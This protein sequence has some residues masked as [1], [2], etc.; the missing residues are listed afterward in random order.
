MKKFRSRIIYFLA[1]FISSGIA[2]AQSG[3]TVINN[4]LPEFEVSSEYG[5]RTH[6][7]YGTERPHN[8]VDL[9]LP[10]SADQ[11]HDI[12]VPEGTM[13]GGT[14]SGYGNYVIVDHG[15][16]VQSFYGHLE[17]YDT[18][19]RTMQVGNTGVGTGSH[20]HY[21]IRIQQ[22]DGTWVQVDPEEA[23][24][25]DLSDPAVRE[26]LVEDANNKLGGTTPTA[27][28]VEGGTGSGGG[29]AG[30]GSAGG[31]SAGGGSAGGG[32]AGGGSA[33]GG[34]AGGGSGGFGG[35]SG[36]PGDVNFGGLGMPEDRTATEGGIPGGD[37][38]EACDEDYLNVLR[39]QAWL[40]GQY[41]ILMNQSLIL[42]PDSVF[43]YTCFHQFLG[44]TSD[45]IAPIFSESQEFEEINIDIGTVRGSRIINT[46][47]ARDE[48]S[49]ADSL[50]SAVIDPLTTYLEN[51]F[52]HTFLGGTSAM[53]GA[54]P[55][56]GGASYTCEAMALVWQIAK[57]TN[58]HPPWLPEM[59]RGNLYEIE[60]FVGY[61]P[62]LYPEECD[63]SQVFQEFIDISNNEDLDYHTVDEPV[64]EGFGS[65]VELREPPCTSPPIPVGLTYTREDPVIVHD[66]VV[67]TETIEF[68]EHVCP[69][70]GC[71]YDP[72][73]GACVQ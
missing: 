73:A 50:T 5:M 29:S 16:G 17:G 60:D 53:D 69:N 55:A 66:L 21:E 57:C 37:G 47:F 32:S 58:F 15:N 34:S 68:Q 25:Q 28:V 14:A 35:G 40:A 6:P 72:E 63:N 27:G 51:N 36:A 43:E 18:E 59:G 70:Q 3:S 24:G 42:K 12:P 2:L 20:L 49:M 11:G 67:D 45:V 62:R 23:W 8:G 61:D 1:L 54:T 30:G 48:G 33:G 19:N 64:P 10:G 9:N 31:G 41:D 65:Y 38:S 26:A 39:S 71:H 7:V 46:G 22:D 4:P 13:T 56:I 44:Y 52:G